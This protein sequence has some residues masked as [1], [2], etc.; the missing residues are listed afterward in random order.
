M[1]LW[2]ALIWRAVF[3]TALGLTRWF[4]IF[5][6]FAGLTM[7][8][9]GCSAFTWAFLWVILMTMTNAFGSVANEFALKRSR[10]LDINVQ[11]A[12][13]YVA[14]ASF[15]ILLLALDEPS[16]L[17]GPTATPMPGELE[18]MRRLP[19]PQQEVWC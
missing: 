1:I 16:R 7:N 6:I 11:N 13:L 9:V 15:A 14:C 8:R 12:I 5:V 19:L 18:N 10:K 4:G 3:H 2:T 17:T